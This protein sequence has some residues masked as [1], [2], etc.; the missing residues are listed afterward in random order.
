MPISVLLVSRSHENIDTLKRGLVTSGY[1]NVK[2]MNGRDDLDALLADGGKFDVAVIHIPDD[3]HESLEDLSA[4][5]ES[6]PRSECIVVSSTNDADLATECLRRG[7]YDYITMPFTREDLASALNAA[8]MYKV[9]VNGHPRILIMEDDPVSGKLMQKFLAP[10]GDC[11]LVVDGIAAVEAFERAVL[12]G[13]IYHLI[14]LDI[15]VPEIH[16][17]EVLKRIREIERKHGIPDSRRSRVIMTT[18]LS[19]SG[20]IVESFKCNCDAYL[21]KPIDKKILIREIT[22]LGINMEITSPS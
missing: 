4:L 18:A 8:V 5:R 15:M 20:N 19:D 12:S 2:I 11:M 14:I 17:K 9:P 10:Y 1:K 21:V 22:G 6:C 13:D 16:G 3:H 7:A